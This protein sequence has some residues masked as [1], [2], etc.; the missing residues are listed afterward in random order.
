MK[1]I[2]GEKPVTPHTGWTIA[3]WAVLTRL[4]KP[5]HD[6]YP[7]ELSSAI[8]K[9]S[10][11]D[12]MRI[13]EGGDLPERLTNEERKHLKA[14]LIKL[15]EEYSNVLY[16]EGRTG[17]SARELKSVLIDAAQ[18]PDFKTLSPLSVLQELRKF[19]KR[20][21]EYEFLRQDP[22]DGYH[23]HEKFIE[24][25]LEQYAGL[26]DREIRECLGLYDT[27]QWGDFMKKYIN[28]LSSLLKKEK[29][30]NP[31]TGGY[32]EPDQALLQEF[33]T[34]VAAPSDADQKNQFRQNL[35]TQIGAWVLDHPKE[36][37]DYFKVFPELR[38]KMEKHFYESQKSLLQKMNL[39]L[40]QFGTDHDDPNS[41]GAKL[42][43]MT[44]ENMQKKFGYT[45]DG[46]KEV[47]HFLMTRK[48]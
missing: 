42:A 35:I 9:L 10:P 37:I 12:K 22:V 4:K 41:E 15:E 45:M 3:L 31:I 40:K 26:I 24:I 36:P 33:E 23:D 32:E 18:S 5:H 29:M 19:V 11:I 14:A 44:I 6:R 48:Y 13:Y 28:H 39:A 8:E 27:R 17:A 25:V 46:A 38:M 20:T 30:K 16:Y 2:A 7:S 1:S 47:I 34:I 21:T 43:R